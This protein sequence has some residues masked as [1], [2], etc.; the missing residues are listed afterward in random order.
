MSMNTCGH[1][2]YWVG[3]Y[4]TCVMC[5]AEKAEAELE[6]AR[7]E[8]DS[9]GKLIGLDYRLDKAKADLAAVRKEL[10]E[11]DAKR[12]VAECHLEESG[13]RLAAALILVEKKDKELAHV[14]KCHP[15]W[16]STKEALA[17][18]PEWAKEELAKMDAVIVAVRARQKLARQFHSRTGD[19][20]LVAVHRADCTLDKALAA[21]REDAKGKGDA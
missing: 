4:G 15:G 19:T 18:T 5:R 10:G 16:A 6:E 3:N 2:E 7:K 21:L 14:L 17:L 20:T 13:I 8:L 11:A 12:C 1:N 9:C